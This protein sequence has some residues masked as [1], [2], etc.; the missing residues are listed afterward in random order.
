MESSGISLI[1]PGVNPEVAW[2]PDFIKKR[3]FFR[4]T[5]KPDRMESIA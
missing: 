5:V 4:E 2:A 1:P 3:G